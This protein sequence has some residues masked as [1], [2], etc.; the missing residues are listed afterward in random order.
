GPCQ[1]IYGWRGAS[2]GNLLRFA[3]DFPLR[4]GGP[5]GRPVPAPVVQLSR[6]FRNGERILEAAARVQDE[7]RAE[8]KAVPRLVPGA[9]REGRGRVECAL[10]ETVEEEAD[11][12]AARIAGLMAGDPETAPDGGPQAEPL[13]YSDIAVLARKRSQFPLISRALEAR[14]VP[15]EVVGLGGPLTVPEVQ[16]VVAT[17]RAMH[18][19]TAG[20]SLARLLTGPRWRL[21]PRRHVPLRRRR[22]APAHEAARA[23]SRRR[24]RATSPRRTGRTARTP[25]RAPG[26]RSPATR[27]RRAATATTRCA[28]SSASSTRRPAAWSTRST[29]SAR[30]R[31]TR[32]RATGG[33]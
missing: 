18:D 6:S 19:P 7:L 32:R 26:R 24:R 31:R 11:R 25:A 17:L 12:I 9:G 21:G 4:P 2:A 15:V 8:T 13:R 28:G 5:G 30:R 1:S 23:P 3:H 20:A 10:F 14:G 27:H 33:C 29:T 22:R 16:D